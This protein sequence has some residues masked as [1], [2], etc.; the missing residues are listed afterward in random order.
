MQKFWNKEELCL[1]DIIESSGSPQRAPDATIRP[2]QLFAIAMPF[3]TMEAKQEQQIL[4]KIEQELLTPMGLRSLG[5]QDPGYQG[6][7]GCGFAHADQ[8]HRDLSYHQG[9][10]WPYLLGFYCDALVNVYG[11]S[12]ETTTRVSLIIQ[13]LLEHLND[14][15]CLGS[16]SE[17][18]D[19]SRPHLA[20]GATASAWSVAEVMRWYSWQ[21][22]R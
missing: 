8:Y 5:P 4:A 11:L 3:R 7:F 10:V 21:T 14:E 2:N 12:P 20:R 16:I 19:G 18:F 1:F 17:L 15:G 6:M 9:T 22:R 13:P